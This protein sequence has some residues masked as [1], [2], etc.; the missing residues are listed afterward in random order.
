MLNHRS[1]LIIVPFL[2]AL[3]LLFPVKSWAQEMPEGVTWDV[4]AEYAVDI[5]GVEMVTLGKF[6]MEPGVVWADYPQ[7]L[8]EFCQVT[9]GTWAVTV[10][11][12]GTTNVYPVGSYFSPP[13]GVTLTIANVG[14][15]VAVQWVY[16]LIET[17]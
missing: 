13:K 3:L 15:E 2:T 4:V 12:T 10:Q 1:S 5:P 7:A 16:S 14:D 6:T 9:Q 11:E 17:E 8:K